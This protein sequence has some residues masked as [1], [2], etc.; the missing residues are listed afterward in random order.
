M[1]APFRRPP[2]GK[3]LPLHRAYFLEQAYL[4]F[5]NLRHPGQSYINLDLF[6]L[7]TYN[8]PQIPLI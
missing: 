8:F 1:F 7:I 6:Y 4:I 3:N 5:G 2:K